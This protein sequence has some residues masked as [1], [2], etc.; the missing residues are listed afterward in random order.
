MQRAPSGKVVTLPHNN[1]TLHVWDDAL[2]RMA[3]HGALTLILSLTLLVPLLVLAFV[4]D[5]RLVVAV[6]VAGSILLAVVLASLTECRNHE[7]IVAV[8]A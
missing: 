6:T 1:R 4:E 3:M 2:V 5:R 7:V 8:S